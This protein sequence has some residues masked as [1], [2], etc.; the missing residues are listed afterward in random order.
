M[1]N[2]RQYSHKETIGKHSVKAETLNLT[3]PKGATKTDTPARKRAFPSIQTS[4]TGNEESPRN[5][6]MRA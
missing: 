3:K 6:H 5:L 2:A 4:Q 1:I